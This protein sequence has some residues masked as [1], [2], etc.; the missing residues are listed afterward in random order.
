[1]HPGMTQEPTVL[2][3]PQSKPL[4]AVTENG[5]NRLAIFLIQISTVQIPEIEPVLRVMIAQQTSEPGIVKF[6]PHPL[7]CGH[8]GFECG[9]VGVEII[10]QQHDPVTGGGVFLEAFLRKEQIQMNVGYDQGFH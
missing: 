8:S 6:L 7:G 1:M 9:I 3:R 4:P 5:L 2:K 10:P